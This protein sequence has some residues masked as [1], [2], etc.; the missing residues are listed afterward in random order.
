MTP[1]IYNTELLQH[2]VDPVTGEKL[3]KVHTK[4]LD[5]NGM[6]II[7]IKTK[8][9]IENFEEKMENNEVEACMS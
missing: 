1:G 6:P 2:D 9:Q 7:E 4:Q 8:D 5:E 3:Y